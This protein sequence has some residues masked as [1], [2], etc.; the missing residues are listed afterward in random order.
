MFGDYIRIHESL[1]KFQNVLS[2]SSSFGNSS[3][4]MHPTAERHHHQ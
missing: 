3:F 1:R 4:R 2:R